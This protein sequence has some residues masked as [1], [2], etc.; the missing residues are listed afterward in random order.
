MTNPSIHKRPTIHDVAKRAGLSTATVSRYI[1]GTAPVSEERAARIEAA[2]QEMQYTPQMAAQVLARSRTQTVGLLLPGIS[3][4]FFA[5]LL[6]GVETRLLKDGY[7]L[8]VHSTQINTNGLRKRVLAEHNTDGLLVFAYSLDNSELKRLNANGF[9][10]VLLHQSSPGGLN[11]PYVTVENRSGVHA[12]IDH[13]IDVHHCKRIAHL[14]GEKG[15]EDTYLREL[16]Y[17]ES[18][19]AHRIP[20]DP[21]LIETG[22]FNA[23]TACQ[24]VQRML[25]K[26][27]HFDGIFAADDESASG[28]M[29]ALRQADIRIPDD[30][31]VVGFDDVN[32][33]AHLSPALTTVHSP[34]EEVAYQAAD[35]LI[36]RIRGEDISQDTQLPTRLIIRNSCGCH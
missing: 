30:V 4:N 34:I 23:E 10:V 6:Q 11:I 29:M 15:H 5:P 16:G 21:N 19:E 25:A 1:N 33:A 8:L 27:I 3:G 32:L 18:L 36:R 22:G 35:Y 12:I 7:S 17:R 2:I 31:A 28:A 24:A 26:G 20:Y 14:L 13:L 9:P